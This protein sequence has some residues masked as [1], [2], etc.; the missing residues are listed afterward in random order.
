MAPSYK[1]SPLRGLEPGEL[2]ARPPQKPGRRVVL[3]RGGGIAR[4]MLVEIESARPCDL[5]RAGGVN[6]RLPALF[7]RDRH[8]AL[9]DGEREAE[10]AAVV[11]AERGGDEAR[12]KAI[13]C[14]ARTLEP[15]RQLAGEQDIGELR[16]PIGQPA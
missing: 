3:R 14:H 7:R 9:G 5:G 13:G 4:T 2:L 12:V 1:A 6:Q 10:R 15:P 16:A 8:E 11:V